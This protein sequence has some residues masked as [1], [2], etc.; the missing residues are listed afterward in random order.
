MACTDLKRRCFKRTFFLFILIFSSRGASASKLGAMYYRS[1]CL[2]ALS[3]KEASEK[4]NYD[5]FPVRDQCGGTC[6]LNA[7]LTASEGLIQQ[8]ISDDY[9]YFVSSLY[10]F[11]GMRYKALGKEGDSAQKFVTLFNNFGFANEGSWTLK[12]G[13]TRKELMAYVEQRFSEEQKSAELGV[14]PA[15]IASRLQNEVKDLFFDNTTPPNKDFKIKLRLDLPPSKESEWPNYLKNLRESFDSGSAMLIITNVK[16]EFERKTGRISYN[17]FANASEGTQHSLV[18]K[19]IR[20]N[21]GSPEFVLQNSWGTSYGIGGD[22]TMSFDTFK[23]VLSGV[24]H[25]NL[26]NLRPN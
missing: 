1:Q 23:K 9:A 8:K 25:L 26:Q 22:Y 5:N 10:R 6:W 13:K 17:P 4:I 21:N 11:D 2:H 7:S 20:L 18:L 12:E 19:D 24:E 16:T 15:L 14:G 3:G